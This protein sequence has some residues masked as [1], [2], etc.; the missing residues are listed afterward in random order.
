MNRLTL[1]MLLLTVFFSA[2]SGLAENDRSPNVL[3]VYSDDQGT[4]DLNC[5]GSTDLETPH[6]DGLAK[7]GIRFTRMYSP[8]AICSSSRAG[9]MRTESSFRT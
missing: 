6:L 8:A 9:L 2:N 4:L 1:A 3:I 5:Y 7:R